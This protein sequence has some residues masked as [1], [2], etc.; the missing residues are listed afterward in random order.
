M[1]EFFVPGECAPQGSK[2]GFFVKA[3]NRVVLAESSAKLKPWRSLVSTKAEQAMGQM[4]PQ[5]CPV[6]A[7]VT[8]WFSRP[9]SHFG[10]GKNK[11][12]L[13]DGVP[14]HKA[15]KPDVDKLIRSVLDAMT[16]IVFQDDSCVVQVFAQKK[17]TVSAPGATI[18]I[19]RIS[20]N[21]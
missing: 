20:E 16:G 6:R 15:S 5:T 9:K 19:E 3:L 17:Y 8:F 10:S 21:G 18:V 7:S 12:R 1:I 2:R 11:D 14:Q 13:K 4:P